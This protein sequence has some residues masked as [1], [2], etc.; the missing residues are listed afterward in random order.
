VLL[1]RAEVCDVKTA[2][3]LNKANQEDNGNNDE[4]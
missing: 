4:N 2:R 1:A 3:H